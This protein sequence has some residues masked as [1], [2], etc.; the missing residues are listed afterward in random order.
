MVDIHPTAVVDRKA[1]LADCVKVGPYCVVGPYVNI[2]EGTELKSH[3]VVEG[4]TFIGK[5]NIFFPFSTIG[6]VPQDKKYR[7]E[8][9]RLIIGN[10]NIIRENCTINIGTEGGG[11]LTSVGDNNW[12]MAYVHIAHDCWVGSHTILANNTGLAGHVVV[13]DW[14]LTGGYTL[15]LQF[16]QL[17]EHSMTA[18]GA[19]VDK[20]VPPYV[21]V[22][23]YKLRP[24]GLNLIGLKRRGFSE[25]QIANIKEVYQLLY[26]EGLSV[27]EAKEKIT[28]LAGNHPELEVFTSFFARSQRPM[29]R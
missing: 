12:I 27:K 26:R 19:R 16:C 13:K 23:G 4:H 11:G 28:A 29:V 6:G 25:A 1:Q 10:G 7:G 21:M 15:V 17:G 18:F 24:A 5:N 2:E 20:D 8:D 3:V 22:A 9:S 14:V